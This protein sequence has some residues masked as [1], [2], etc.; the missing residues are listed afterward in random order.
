[1]MRLRPIALL[2]VIAGSS[3]GAQ[4]PRSRA[5]PPP[6]E[7]GATVQFAPGGD[8]L[9]P[10]QGY[11]VEI[12]SRATRDLELLIRIE[13]DSC[14]GVALRREHLAPGGRKRVFLYSPGSSY[15]RSIPPRYRI[16]DGS[17]RELA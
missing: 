2:L 17:D 14:S 10:W 6:S 8:L 12:D 11:S 3:F 1:M 4:E 15:P 13:D 7:L 5:A 9:G 16:T